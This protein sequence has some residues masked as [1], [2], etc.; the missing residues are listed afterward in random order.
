MHRIDHSTNNA[1]LPAPDAAGTP[2]YFKKGDPGLGVPATVVT[3]DWANSMQEELAYV[4]L[5]AGLVLS[6]TDNT[7]LRQAIQ[8]M[9]QSANSAVIITGATFEASVANGEAVRW[10]STN[11]RFDEA[12]A[13]GTANNQAAGFA[14]VTNGKVYCYGETPALFAGLT[15]GARYYLSAATAGAITT[16]PPTDKVFMGIAKSAT[17]LFVDIDPVA[18]NVKISGD[19]VGGNRTE[20][21]TTLGPLTSTIPHD[22][23][24]PQSGEGD[25]VLTAT[26]YAPTKAGNKIRFRAL[27]NFSD[28]ATNDNTVAA[29]FKNGD[30]NAVGVGSVNSGT[31]GGMTQI[32]IA[33]EFNSVDTNPIT[34][35]LRIGTLA[36]AQVFING[37]N[38]SRLYGGK[39]KTWIEIDEIEA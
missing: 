38:V 3:Q 34:L 20:L 14:D 37:N 18:A 4:I 36:G 39:L 31:V 28:Q 16:T 2:G 21:T 25:L 7:Q 26:A 6:K 22:D 17:V 30:A 1:S 13:D 5:Q 24:I 8:S 32:L 12:I 10:D 23:T 29:V 33:D 11:S 15:P 35:T 9:I 27:V 19:R